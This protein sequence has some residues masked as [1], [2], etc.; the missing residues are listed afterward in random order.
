M[1]THSKHTD[2][3]GVDRRAFLAYSSAALATA[4]FAPRLIA[5]DSPTGVAVGFAEIEAVENGRSEAGPR[6]VPARS[7]LLGAG[8]F[9]SYGARVRIAGVGRAA[10]TPRIAGL[11]AHYVSDDGTDVP[12]FAWG[13]SGRAGSS[14]LVTFHMPVDGTQRLRF[15]LPEAQ[16]RQR[17][18]GSRAAASPAREVTLSLLSGD[19]A[20]KLTRGYYVIVP[21]FPGDG[22]PSW[23]SLTLARRSGHLV[24]HELR[25]EELRPIEREHIVLRIEYGDRI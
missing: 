8:A 12:V 15:S 20:I 14:G 24:L 21:L 18:A 10:G 25:G 7:I 13:A 5:E 22:T 2:A 1:N 17:A 11:Q 4:A 3:G 9:L 6:L 23:S 16:S 19:G